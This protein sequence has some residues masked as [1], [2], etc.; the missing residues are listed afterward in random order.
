M[1]EVVVSP[2]ALLRLNVAGQKRQ[3]IIAAC[4]DVS[5]EGR[6]AGERSKW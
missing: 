3:F 4:V 6:A 2:P 1:S 5:Y